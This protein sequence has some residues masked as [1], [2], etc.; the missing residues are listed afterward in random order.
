MR[1]S[2]KGLALV[3]AQEGYHA[4]QKDGGC[5]AYRCPAGVWTCGWGCTE[6][7][8]A[9]TLWTI[10]EATDALRRE[11][12]RHEANVHKMV[13]VPLTQG[14]FD[15][16]VSI[17]YNI[18]AGN[19]KK[20]N[21][22]RHLNAGDYARAASHFADFKYAKVQGDTARHY[23]VKDGTSVALAGLVSRRAAETALFL[24]SAPVDS[25]PQ[26]VQPPT[27]KMTTGETM[28][29]VAAPAT[30]GS[31]AVATLVQ[32]PPDLS[33]VT[34]WKTAATEAGALLQW[35]MANW[36]LTAAAG[37]AYV[38]MAHLLPWWQA[39]RA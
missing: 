38:I 6:G 23:K 16:L 39:R 10:E 27:S 5:K 26:K 14:Q 36:M 7:V 18:G 1:I 25:M 34:A 11:M 22:L 21:L 19:L 29:K 37:A 4:K 15:A 2:D 9:N 35:A 13:T 31:G 8:E 32:S 24:E 28:A 30:V 12:A 20:S 33:A 17:C 3:K